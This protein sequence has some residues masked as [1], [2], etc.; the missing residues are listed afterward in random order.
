MAIDLASLKFRRIEID[1]DIKPFDCGDDDLN[2]FLLEDAKNYINSMLAVTYLL[3]DE[4]ADKTVA[5]YCLLNDKIGLDPDEKSKWNKINRQIPNDKRYHAYPAVKI[6][7]FAVSKEFAGQ[8]IGEKLILQIKMIFSRLNLSGCRF[9]T[10]D[11]YCNA[12]PFY[13][14]CGFKFLTDK[15]ENERTRAMYFDL[16]YYKK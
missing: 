7:R 5:Y 9:L 12:I 6:G 15:D 11:A 1:T 3:E 2:E 14:K 4:K 10:V 13:Q 16:M 8:R